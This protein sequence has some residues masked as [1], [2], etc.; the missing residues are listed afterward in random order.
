MH[1]TR[2][3]NKDSIIPSSNVFRINE[4]K[5][6]I[7]P[8]KVSHKKNDSVELI[9]MKQMNKDLQNVGNFKIS[10]NKT[11]NFDS[12]NQKKKG[13][14]NVKNDKFENGVHL[15]NKGSTIKLVNKLKK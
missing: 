1:S 10:L 11:Y 6:S 13:F 14:A 9:H 2:F 3:Q 7:K 12:N 5:D 8:I 4:T 15:E